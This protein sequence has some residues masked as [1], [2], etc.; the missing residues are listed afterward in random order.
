MVTLKLYMI[1]LGCKPN[2]RNTEQHDVFFGI[3]NSLDELYPDLID[4]W[5]E[6][7]EEI[8]IDAWREVN[9]VDGYKIEIVLRESKT[10]LSSEERLFFIN[11]G[12]YQ[13][14]KFEEQHHFVLS[15]QQ[16]KMSAVKK[17]K[18]TFFFQN[19][20]FG[21]AA[22]HIDE[23]YGIDVD[24]IHQI[25]DMLTPSHKTK[26][27]MIISSHNGPEIDIIHLGYHRLPE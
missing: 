19:N 22:S 18:D 24:D 10:H 5:P 9:F 13:E 23:K 27:K 25:D 14:M 11:L 6:A 17:A 1:L 16:N 8:H 2:G 15:V 3:G 20:R 7:K 12:G 4:F 21:K 26:Y